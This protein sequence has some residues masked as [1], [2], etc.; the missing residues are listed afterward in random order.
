MKTVGTKTNNDTIEIA[1]EQRAGRAQRATAEAGGRTM[2][3]TDWLA[4]SLWRRSGGGLALQHD[5]VLL[6]VGQLG[7][8]VNRH[9]RRHVPLSR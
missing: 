7:A 6:L 4:D 8:R 5:V 3:W 2:N 9:H 1:T